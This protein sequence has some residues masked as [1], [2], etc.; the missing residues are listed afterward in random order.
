MLAA[1]LYALPS[2]AQNSMYVDSVTFSP[3]NPDAND[4]VYLHVYG[5]SGYGTSLTGTP[6]VTTVNTYYHTVD[7][8]YTVGLITVVTVIHDSV[9]LFTGPAGQHTVQWNI[10]QNSSQNNCDQMVNSSQQLLNVSTVLGLDETP[11]PAPVLV[12]NSETE[13]LFNSIPG[14]LSIYDSKGSLVSEN[15]LNAYQ[16]S[17]LPADANGI[18]IAV[19][20]NEKGE[21]TTLRFFKD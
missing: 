7:I 6:T 8:C 20:S 4:A 9:Y 14:K 18:Y 17:S 15:Y 16:T 19:F 5:W 11:P 10:V 13:G 2:S 21:K 3:V 12:W 1:L